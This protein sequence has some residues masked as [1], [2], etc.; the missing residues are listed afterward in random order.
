[1]QKLLA[2]RRVPAILPNINEWSQLEGGLNIPEF[3]NHPGEFV[4][5]KPITHST[6][7]L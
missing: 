3:V 7:E 4:I 2:F 6:V 5:I 1:V